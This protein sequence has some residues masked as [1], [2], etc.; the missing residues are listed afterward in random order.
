MTNLKISTR[1]I[2]LLGVLSALL[3]VIG[4]IGLYGIGQSNDALKTVYEDR[5]AP[6]GQLADIQRLLLRNRLSLPIR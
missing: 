2:A 4:G 1:L 6:M 3:I 5:T